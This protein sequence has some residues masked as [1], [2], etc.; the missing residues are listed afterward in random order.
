MEANV[1][2][3]PIGID[4]ADVSFKINAAVSFAMYSF[5]DVNE[6]K[7]MATWFK[8]QLSQLR[9][10]RSDLIDF[11]FTEEELKI[12][13]TDVYRGS[14]TTLTWSFGP[15]YWIARLYSTDNPAHTFMTVVVELYEDYRVMVNER[16][17]RCVETALRLYVE[18]GVTRATAKKEYPGN[19]FFVMHAATIRGIRQVHGDSSVVF[20]CV[21]PL[22]HAL[23]LLEPY[24]I[25][26]GTDSRREQEELE[27]EYIRKHSMSKEAL[28]HAFQYSIVIPVDKLSLAEFQHDGIGSCIA[29]TRSHATW[30]CSDCA[31]VF[32][33][34]K[35]YAAQMGYH[36]RQCIGWIKYTRQCTRSDDQRV[37]ERSGRLS[38]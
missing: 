26:T 25:L 29:C 22:E 30:E 33:G 32:C 9:S 21:N 34:E 31:A 5:S 13:E 8:I 15:D 16:I 17:G 35:C 3:F 14:W 1:N 20:L 18:E 10:R 2:P 37:F 24:S 36:K 12:L 11:G 19:L 28:E 7:H 6:K 38:M 4:S 27:E 23:N